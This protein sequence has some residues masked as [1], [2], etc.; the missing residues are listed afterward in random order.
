MF[1][2]LAGQIWFDGNI[3]RGKK[4]VSILWLMLYIMLVVPVKGCA[5]IIIRFCMHM[6]IAKDCISQLILNFKIPYS[7]EELV[8]ATQH[9]VDNG[10]YDQRY[11]RAIAWCGSK[12]ITVS[13]HDVDVH[14]SVGI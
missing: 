4:F 8:S 5:L 6:N 11:T 2:S 13:N 12:S 7:I 14:T 10:N 9:L 1:D 3:I